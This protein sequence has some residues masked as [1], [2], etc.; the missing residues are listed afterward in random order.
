[1]WGAVPRLGLDYWALRGSKLWGW[2][3]ISSLSFCLS[4]KHFEVHKGL[5]FSPPLPLLP[6]LESPQLFFL[7]EHARSYQTILSSQDWL[8]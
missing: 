8:H 1:M 7:R 2:G 4:R 5:V 3:Q 6:C